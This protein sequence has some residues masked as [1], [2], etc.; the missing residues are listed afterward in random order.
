MTDPSLIWDD[1]PDLLTVNETAT[2]LRRNVSTIYRRLE[3][4]EWPFAW[5]DGNDWRIEK[6][7]LL[8]HLRHRP[9]HTRRPACDPMPDPTRVRFEQMLETE[10]RRAA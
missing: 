4:G 7:A 6:D 9:I 10:M 3:R 8:D 1:A 5:K 2:L